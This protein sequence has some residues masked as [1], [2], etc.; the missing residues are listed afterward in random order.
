M[1]DSATDIIRVHLERE[2][3]EIARGLVEIMAIARDVGCQT[4]VAIRSTDGTID[5]IAACAGAKGRRIARIVQALDGERVDLVQWD[6]DPEVNI[7]HA[8]AP[9]E[10]RSVVIDEQQLRATAFVPIAQSQR[11][12]GR[13]GTNLRLACELCGY[14]IVVEYI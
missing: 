12:L 10:I 3:P 4:K 8:L 11:V 9:A 13:R 6:D 14:T 7:R 2:V 5:S 1:A